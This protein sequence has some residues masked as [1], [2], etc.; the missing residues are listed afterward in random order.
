MLLSFYID[1]LVMKASP[2]DRARLK[3]WKD[4]DP[5]GWEKLDEGYFFENLTSNDEFSWIPEGVTGDLTSAPMLGIY[6]E[7]E[8][9]PDDYADNWVGSGLVDCGSAVVQPVLYRWAFMDYAVTTPMDALLNDGEAVWM[10]GKFLERGQ[11][12]LPEW[13]ANHDTLVYPDN[14][15]I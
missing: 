3:K 4:E 1:R 6:G 9:E 2:E 11:G 8:D 5:D 7:E 14:Y 13:R 12:D 15:Q 10:G